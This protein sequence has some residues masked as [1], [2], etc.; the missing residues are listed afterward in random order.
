[1]RVTR[2]QSPTTTPKNDEPRYYN[3][4][5]A[6]PNSTDSNYQP[7]VRTNLR[8]IDIISAS[9]NVSFFCYHD[10]MECMY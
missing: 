6:T 1:M 4:N 10:V 3:M 9:Y 8:G 5:V 7:K 2:V